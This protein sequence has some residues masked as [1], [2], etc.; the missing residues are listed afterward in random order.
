[1]VYLRSL[2]VGIV[3][4]LAAAALWILAVFVL[5][6]AVPLLVSRLPG[7]EY[8]TGGAGAVISEGSILAAALVG[9][10]V[11]YCWEFRRART[12]RG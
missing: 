3:V 11:G 5:P 12:G 6:I 10:I 2:L 4:A 9:L 1:M 7:S 8:G